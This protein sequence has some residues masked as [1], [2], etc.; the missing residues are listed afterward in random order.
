[1]AF[2][3]YTVHFQFIPSFYVIPTTI[4]GESGPASGVWPPPH[5]SA[6]H[7]HG[8]GRPLVPARPL[9]PPAMDAAGRAKQFCIFFFFRRFPK[10]SDFFHMNIFELFT[11]ISYYLSIFNFFSTQ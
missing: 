5:R 10:L 8:R 3:T 11:E 6:R 2:F 9:V 1:V 7:H 4:R